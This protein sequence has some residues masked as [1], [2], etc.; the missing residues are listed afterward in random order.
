MHLITETL[1][2]GNI[3]DARDP[4]VK[5]GALLLLAGEYT[6]ES[7]KWVALWQDSIFRVW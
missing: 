3:N 4:P 2:V 5:I 7:R 6:L 1:L